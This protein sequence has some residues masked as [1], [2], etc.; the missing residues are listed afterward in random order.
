M[1]ELTPETEE[2]LAQ[3][4]AGTP[5]S[6]ARRDELK[7]GVLAKIALGA[8]AAG[9]SLTATSTSA[10]AW[11]MTTKTI[12]VAV[13][14]AVIGTGTV[15]VVHYQRRAH[16][17]Q[18]SAQTSQPHSVPVAANDSPAALSATA[19]V[20]TAPSLSTGS[21]APQT[22]PIVPPTRDVAPPAATSSTPSTPTTSVSHPTGSPS[23][24][25]TF[26]D[27]TPIAADSRAIESLPPPHASSLEDETSLLRS[28]H[29]ALHANDPA[30]AIRLL[31][32]HAARFPSGPLAEDAS[33]ERVFAFCAEQKTDE[34]RA[35]AG[36]FLS[37]HPTGPLAARVRA[38]CGGQ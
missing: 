26:P 27:D 19:S 3:G 7:D 9:T 12:G 22:F 8:G 36:T 34:A 23:L 10:A 15:G 25:T 35:A 21:E 13:I 31:D 38:S 11:T 6:T 32:E 17:P 16:A 28:A 37:A 24:V 30:R 5:L 14:A 1:S 20:A 29:E 33:A 18:A 4:R 2:L